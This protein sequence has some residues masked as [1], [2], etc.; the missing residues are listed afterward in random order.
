[1]KNGLK[2]RKRKAKVATES[3]CSS[4]LTRY[5]ENVI[6]KMHMEAN[7]PRLSINSS[8]QTEK[9]SMA[10][11]DSQV[12]TPGH[13]VPSFYIVPPTDTKS[14]HKNTLTPT[15]SRTCRERPPVMLTPLRTCLSN[16]YLASLGQTSLQS[17]SKDCVRSNLNI[18]MNF[19]LIFPQSPGQNLGISPSA[20]LQV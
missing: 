3:A 10:G 6:E 4:Q 19:C 17:P 8:E 16:H 18:S 11:S 14:Q 15:K 9:P 2:K 1:M 5:Y 13:E 20:K 12:D 7:Q